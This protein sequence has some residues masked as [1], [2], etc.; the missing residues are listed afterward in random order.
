VNERPVNPAPGARLLRLWRQ[1]GSLPGGAWWFSRILGWTVPYSGTL[2]ARVEALEPGH[3]R[4]VIRERRALS[5]HLHSIHA[6]ALANLGE[7]TSGLATTV[8]LPA[9]VRG[10]V[11]ALSVEYLKKARGTIRAECTCVAPEVREA[12]DFEV[13]TLLTD[14]AGD[15]VA[16][17][18]VRWRLA[19]ERG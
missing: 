8:A 1:L 13:I 19:P 17:V 15:T 7:L 5:N 14:S 10:I 12:V 9:G 4:L 16:R 3:A 11:T 2:G 6:L 18:T